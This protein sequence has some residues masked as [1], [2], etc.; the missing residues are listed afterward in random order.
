[1]Y[2]SSFFLVVTNFFWYWKE[3]GRK[4]CLLCVWEG[5]GKGIL[6]TPGMGRK[7]E[8]NVKYYKQGKEV[9]RI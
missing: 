3:M 7:W 6:C 5:N 1:M 4:L 2:F 8:G 9:G